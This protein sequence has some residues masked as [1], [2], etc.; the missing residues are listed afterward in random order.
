[1]NSV[2]ERRPSRGSAGGFR[3]QFRWSHIGRANPDIVTMRPCRGRGATVNAR[4][5]ADER[6]DRDRILLT[7]DRL[8][9][10]RRPRRQHIDLYAA[11]QLDNDPARFR[12]RVFPVAGGT[13]VIARPPIACCRCCCCSP[14]VPTP[15]AEGSFPATVA[16]SW[17]PGWHRRFRRCKPGRRS[18]PTALASTTSAA[19]AVEQ[20][21][22]QDPLH[23]RCLGRRPGSW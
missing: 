4:I 3:G 16:S 21:E 6:A 23:S 7:P 13:R 14:M 10:V 5:Q 1:M 19:F 11:V 12:H 17:S 20:P 22:P 8:A 2:G 9:M 15:R 18:S